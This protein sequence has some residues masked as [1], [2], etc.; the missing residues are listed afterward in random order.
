MGWGLSNRD[1]PRHSIPLEKDHPDF[2]PIPLNTETP[3]DR[4]APPVD[5][6]DIG[7]LYKNLG[8][9]IIPYEDNNMH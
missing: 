5:H 4:T 6:V 7:L 9:P 8:L 3:I 2:Y 1:P